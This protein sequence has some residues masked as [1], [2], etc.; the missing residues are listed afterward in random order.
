[1]GSI[2]SS[3]DNLKC[4]FNYGADVR[5]ALDACNYH[6][7][8]QATGNISFTVKKNCPA[9]K[10]NVLIEG[11]ENVFWEKRISKSVG[12]GA[13]RR[14]VSKVIKIR[15]KV[16]TV[17]SRSFV[18]ETHEGF[19]P[20]DYNY[21]ISFPVP[22]GVAGTYAYS[23]TFGLDTKCSSSY[24][25]YAEVTANDPSNKLLGR[26]GAP[27]VIMQRPKH[28]LQQEVSMQL[29]TPLKTWFCIDRG[30][31]HGDF[32]FEKNIVC[33]DEKVW[34]KCTLDNTKSNLSVDDVSCYLKRIL[35]L[36]TRKGQTKVVRTTMMKQVIG[37]VKKGEKSEERMVE[38]DL[39]MAKDDGTPKKLQGSLGEFAGKIQQTCSGQLIRVHYELEM[40][41]DFVGC[42]CCDPDPEAILPI[43][44]VAPEKVIVFQQEIYSA[45][46]FPADQDGTMAPIMGDDP[47]AAGGMMTA[48]PIMDS[49]APM[50]QM[51]P[52]HPQQ[53][54]PAPV[55]APGGAALTLGP[56]TVQPGQAQPGQVQYAQQPA[57]MPAA[58]VPPQA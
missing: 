43:E 28:Q 49:Q 14:R 15:D 52:A 12:R 29:N 37:G 46:F 23:H 2:F 10:L 9:I 34:M 11:Y 32:V 13:N 44:I 26:G 57:P 50:Q 20:G 38:F 53:V 24:M 6:E 18:M 51:A 27:I 48:H 45:S 5:I 39:N 33:M 8:A 30:N 3:E 40:E 7:G 56:A 41:V 1:M 31:F 19:L 17:T 25:V 21:P 36:T 16:K 54:A 58:G 4:F 42:R 35:T 55:Q 22:Q 47:S